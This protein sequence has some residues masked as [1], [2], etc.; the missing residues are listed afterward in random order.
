MRLTNEF[1]TVDLVLNEAINRQKQMK[2]TTFIVAGSEGMGKTHFVL[3]CIDR[4]DQKIGTLT[5]IHNIAMELKTYFLALR[6][7]SVCDRISLDEGKELMAMNHGDKKV[8]D[9]VQITTVIRKKRLI[10][11]LCFGN[12]TKIA[13]YFREDKVYGI[14]LMAKKTSDYTIVH[15]YTRTQFLRILDELKLTRSMN[16]LSMLKHPPLFRAILRGSYTGRLLEAYENRKDAN[17]DYQLDLLVDT[18]CKDETKISL[19][20]ACRQL[21]ISLRTLKRI[22]PVDFIE[23]YRNKVN[24]VKFDKLAM[25]KMKEMLDNHSKKTNYTFVPKLPNVNNLLSNHINKRGKISPEITV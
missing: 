16:I 4:L 6:D 5:P 3:K 2:E 11:F 9:A 22:V 23:A 19:Q 20:E 8:K 15:Y 12:P 13:H 18:Y 17:I 14:F 10:S 21:D 7:S 25:E 24:Q 1:E